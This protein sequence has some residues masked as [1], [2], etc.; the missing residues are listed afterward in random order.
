MLSSIGDDPP[1]LAVQAS[2]GF[3]HSSTS[4]KDGMMSCNENETESSSSKGARGLKV[5]DVRHGGLL[6]FKRAQLPH[7]AS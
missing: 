3:W 4:G 7:A 1:E 5:R 6:V 2:C